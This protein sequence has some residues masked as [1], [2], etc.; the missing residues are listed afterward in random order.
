LKRTSP[1]P[2]EE[3]ARGE[4]QA[5]RSQAESR[6]RRACSRSGGEAMHNNVEARV[7][8]PDLC[9]RSPLREPRDPLAVGL[10]PSRDFNKQ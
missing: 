2:W 9:A 7:I 8:H 10:L 1:A 6:L 5:P 4:S 3:L